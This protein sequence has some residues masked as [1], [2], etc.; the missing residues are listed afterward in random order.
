[1]SYLRETNTVPSGKQ[2]H[3]Y[4]KSPFSMG[5]S[6]IN[7]QFLQLCW[8][9][10]RVSIAS[11]SRWD[12]HAHQQQFTRRCLSRVTRSCGLNILRK[13]FPWFHHKTPWFMMVMMYHHQICLWYVYDIHHGLWSWSL[14]ISLSFD[15]SSNK[16]C[17]KKKKHTPLGSGQFFLWVVGVSV[18]LCGFCP[19]LAEKIGCL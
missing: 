7:G 9:N 8:H 3:S 2:P 4:G 15:G 13:E 14:K 5:K 6:T 19:Y 17:K 11:P 10:Q 12:P 18:L 16:P 1:M